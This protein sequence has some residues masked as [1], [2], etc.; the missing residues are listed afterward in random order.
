MLSGNPL[1]S[2][3][4]SFSGSICL[5]PVSRMI[6]GPLSMVSVRS[7]TIFPL[8]TMI[9]LPI[10]SVTSF[11]FMLRIVIPGV[12]RPRV[13]RTVISGSCRTQGR[14]MPFQRFQLVFWIFQIHSCDRTMFLNFFCFTYCSLYF[15]SIKYRLGSLSYCTLC[16]QYSDPTLYSKFAIS[17]A[18]QKHV[19][20]LM[21]KVEK[22]LEYYRGRSMTVK[23][24]IIF[25]VELIFLC[26]TRS[27]NDWKFLRN[28]GT[29]TTRYLLFF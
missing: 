20:N 27:L 28:Y 6:S 11:I 1:F 15:F 3:P 14:R 23:S 19:I 5:P 16:D 21:N 7:L 12:T 26:G 4:I 18:N 24:R 2:R 10:T 25:R 22:I 17:W 29:K 8:S 9:F 13:L